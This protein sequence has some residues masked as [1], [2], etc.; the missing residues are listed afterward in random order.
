M[1]K[2]LNFQEACRHKTCNNAFI[3]L[4]IS[5]V[6]S[7]RLDKLSFIWKR[8]HC[9]S[10]LYSIEQRT[11]YIRTNL[12][13]MIL[14]IFCKSRWPILIVRL[15]LIINGRKWHDPKTNSMNSE[16]QLI[17][18]NKP[19]PFRKLT[20]QKKSKFI[21]STFWPKLQ[22]PPPLWLKSLLFCFNEFL[23][24]FS[25][26]EPWTTKNDNFKYHI[27]TH[28]KLDKDFDLKVWL[29]FLT[30]WKPIKFSISKTF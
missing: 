18:D 15:L 23:N 16:H 28:K 6:F 12:F 17:I 19:D 20:V 11:R 9:V 3:D 2:H 7:V 26:D 30:T 29:M 5:L 24:I 13:L 25:Y 27:C 14:S 21:R 8:L 4:F 10:T 1:Y 22:P